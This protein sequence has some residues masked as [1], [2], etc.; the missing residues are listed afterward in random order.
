MPV[1][2]A[3]HRQPDE[4]LMYIMVQHMGICTNLGNES[5]CTRETERKGK[6]WGIFMKMTTTIK[7]W[8]NSLAIRIPQPI[9]KTINISDGSEV[10]LKVTGKEIRIIPKE[11]IPTLE[12]LLAQ[13]TPDNRHNYI[14]FDRKGKELI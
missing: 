1:L 2:V 8:G 6:E 4:E 7:K 5:V 10:T 13:I 12:D 3:H 11:K 14:D 9:A